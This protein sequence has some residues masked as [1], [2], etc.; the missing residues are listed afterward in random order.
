MPSKLPALLVLFALMGLS[1]CGGGVSGENGSDPFGNGGTP[2]EVVYSIGLEILNSQCEAV[3]SQSFTSGD[4][5]CLQA[6]LSQNGVAVSGEIISFSTGL[7]NL[8]VDTK[9]SNGEG[10][11]EVTLS[12][13]SA[14]VGAS[15]ISVTFE[16]VSADA[17][18]EFLAGEVTVVAQPL[19]N[20]SMLNNG[21]A[22]NRF[23]ADE[24]VQL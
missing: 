3:S 13:D 20:I 24:T 22:V 17:N 21:E 9:L 2:T 16:T 8:S 10:I 5:L 6:T 14:T 7:G 1:G 12:S 23:K 4:T 18:F 15:T 19:I 11:A